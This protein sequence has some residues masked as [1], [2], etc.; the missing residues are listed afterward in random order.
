M[1]EQ[2]AGDYN[3]KLW[4]NY[5]KRLCEGTGKKP[6]VVRKQKK[7]IILDD[8]PKIFTVVCLRAD[9]HSISQKLAISLVLWL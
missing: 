6:K 8:F 9:T 5:N 1:S 3:Y 4:T 2:L 7:R